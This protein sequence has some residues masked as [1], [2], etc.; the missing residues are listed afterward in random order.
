[1]LN[2]FH[3][4]LQQFGIF[5]KLAFNSLKG[6]FPFIKNYLSFRVKVNRDSG[7]RMSR[8]LPN[9]HDRYGTAA[10]IPLHYFHQDIL[11]AKKIF[12]ACP[13]KHVDVGSRIDG[14]VSILAVFREVEVFD[15]RPLD[16][17]ISNVKFLQADL[18][19]ESFPY[20]DYCD[21]VSCLHAIEHFG[22]GR[23][24]DNID[25]DGHLK[26]LNN[27]YK[28]LSRHGKFYFSTIIGP[29]RIEFDAHR[30]F[31]IEYLMNCFS[32][33]Y[34]IESFSYINDDNELF[35]NAELDEKNILSN[36]GCLYGCGIFELTKL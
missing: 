29:Q 7:F 15:I 12:K 18:M 1:L 3:H 33:K 22:L 21:S 16:L 36:F 30:V 13:E 17:K 2:P 8:L 28:I 34:K 9:F 27:M 14:F 24:G 25:P 5:P 6:I 19:S 20:S 23:Y 35:E 10:E 26:G 4:I 32:G 11:T 31:S